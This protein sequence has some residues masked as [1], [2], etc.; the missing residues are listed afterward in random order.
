MVKKEITPLRKICLKKEN[1]GRTKARCTPLANARGQVAIF[2]MVG[3]VIVVSI[4]L[5]FFLQKKID[6]STFE[7]ENPQSFIRSCVTD[8]IEDSETILLANGGDIVPQHTIPYYDE[9]YNYLCYQADYYLQ[10][11]NTH[12]QLEKNVEAQLLQNTQEHVENCF[13]LLEEEYNSRG[14]SISSGDLDYSVDI[15]PGSIDVLLFKNIVISRGDSSEEYRNFDFEVLSPIYDLIEISRLIVND[16]SQ[17]CNFEYTGYMLLY[18]QYSISRIDF[19]R[20]KLYNVEHRDSLKSFKF[21]VRSCAFPPGI[22][23]GKR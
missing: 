18:P 8:S 19:E 13:N 1:S 20:S 21:A 17:F 9:K 10:C 4:L 23:L 15:L 7:V 2:V 22:Q 5:F 16:E 14:F 3:I 11:Y 12:P 6:I